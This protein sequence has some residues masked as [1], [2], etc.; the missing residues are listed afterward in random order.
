MSFD[1]FGPDVDPTEREELQRL[2]S[3]LVAERPVPAAAFRGDLRRRIIVA[4]PSGRRLQLRIASYLATGTALLAVAAFGV[5]DVGPLAPHPLQKE[6][7][8][9]QAFVQR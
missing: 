6:P 7:A 2:A 3:R 8:A 5:N 9:T 1:D 4:R